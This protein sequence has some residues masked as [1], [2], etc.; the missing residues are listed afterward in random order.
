L[1]AIAIFEIIGAFTRYLIN[2]FSSKITGKGSKA[3]SH[4]MNDKKGQMSSN[5]T[6]D[7]AN[8][9]IGFLVFSLTLLLFYILLK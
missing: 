7:Y 8:G 6:N 9:I 2:N 5:L 3:L 1:I 4:Y